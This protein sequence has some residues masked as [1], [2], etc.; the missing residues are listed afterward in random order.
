MINQFMNFLDY[1]K[2]GLTENVFRDF[3]NKIEG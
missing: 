1:M 2:S 3:M